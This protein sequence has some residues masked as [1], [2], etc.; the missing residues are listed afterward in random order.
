MSFLDYKCVWVE[1]KVTERHWLPNQGVIKCQSVLKE[2]EKET[3][4]RN[5]NSGESHGDRI[6]WV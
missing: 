5:S 4:E 1:A 3:Q 6:W 2:Y